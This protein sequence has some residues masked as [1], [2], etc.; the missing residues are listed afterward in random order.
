MF[1]SYEILTKSMNSPIEHALTRLSSCN[2]NQIELGRHAEDMVADRNIDEQL[3]YDCLIG[4]EASG[5]IQQRTKRFKLF[6]KQD[7]SRNK[8]D[9]IIIIDFEESNEKHIKVV[10]I[11]EQSVKVRER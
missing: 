11:Y 1:I 10:T 6:Y 9:L 8:Y 7:G 4:K 3:V 5:I 2:Q